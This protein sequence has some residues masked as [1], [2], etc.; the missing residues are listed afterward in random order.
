MIDQIDRQI[1]LLLQKDARLSNAEL[2][3]QVGLTASSV[4]ERVKKLQNK[5]VIR[6][7]VALVD[8]QAVGKTITAFIRLT[9]AAPPDRPYAACKRD[10]IDACLAEPD[11]LE[12]HGVAGED[13]YI[14]KIRV[15]DTGELEAM[16]DRLRSNAVI[17]SSVSSIVLSTM[18][19][20]TLVEPIV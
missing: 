4:Y 19:E 5:G 16:L 11:V 6:G 17:S 7:F 10:F 9:V 1:L 12:C 3:E 14:L 20:T 2:G 18:K 8:P 15:G 13:C